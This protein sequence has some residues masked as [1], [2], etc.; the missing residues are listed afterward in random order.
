MKFNPGFDI[1]PTT[2][3]GVRIWE[4]CVRSAGGESFSQ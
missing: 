1:V 4:R 2:T 3:Y